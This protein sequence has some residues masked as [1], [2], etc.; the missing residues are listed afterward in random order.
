MIM[1]SSA[2]KPGGSTSR[3]SL[4]V[5]IKVD[6]RP[7]TIRQWEA[8]VDRERNSTY[9]IQSQLPSNRK[10]RMKVVQQYYEI[11]DHYGI[12]RSVVGIAINYFDRFVSNYSDERHYLL[13]AMTCIYLA[14]KIHSKIK[15]S[16][17]TMVSMGNGYFT[18]SD[19]LGMEMCIFNSFDWYMNPPIPVDFLTVVRPLINESLID[20]TIK[21]EFKHL[22]QYLIE[23]GLYF[24]F[25]SPSSVAYAAMLVAMKHLSIPAE[26]FDALHLEH[27]PHMTDLWVDRLHQVYS[28]Q[29]DQIDPRLWMPYSSSADAR[30]VSKKRKRSDGEMVRAENKCKRLACASPTDVKDVFDNN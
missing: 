20:L 10:Q 13:A 8:L 21:T 5:A 30:I 28:R 7:E 18:R 19:L 26:W 16:A 3:R 17:E 15:I 4:R 14:A 24:P 22:V 11:V 23:L 6:C 29:I 1:A 9:L 25:E 27:T 12:D 2:R